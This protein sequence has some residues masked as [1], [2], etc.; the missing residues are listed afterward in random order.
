MMRIYGFRA[1]SLH[2]QYS[3]G[4]VFGVLVARMN[5]FKLQCPCLFGS[6]TL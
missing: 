4:G 6:Q 5:P 1:F 3:S 2:W